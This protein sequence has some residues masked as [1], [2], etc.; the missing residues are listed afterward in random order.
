M[1]QVMSM[2]VTVEADVH[3]P[4]LRQSARVSALEWRTVCERHCTMLL[5][6]REES[7][8]AAL[9]LLRPHLLGM[10]HWKQRRA[11]LELPR[12][13]VQTL[14]LEDVASLQATEQANLLEWLAGADTPVQVV[15]TTTQ[16][17]FP[18]VASG[19]FDERLYYRL[20]TVFLQ[21]D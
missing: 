8:D 3:A 16:P 5:E 19:I 7:T 9:L 15:S 14:I 4:E 11:T 12:R 10:V 17:L 21:I 18:F 20:N 2:P 1:H 13:R 6:G